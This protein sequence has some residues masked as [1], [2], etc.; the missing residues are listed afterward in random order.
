MP[1]KEYSLAMFL[2]DR[3]RRPMVIVTALSAAGTRQVFL[4]RHMTR[5]KTFQKKIFSDKFARKMYID[6]A[7]EKSCFILLRR[8]FLIENAKVISRSPKE[9]ISS[10]KPAQKFLHFVVHLLLTTIDNLC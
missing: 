7:Y 2:R 8:Y 1:T 9:K 5:K 3:S 4:W 6:I 10:P